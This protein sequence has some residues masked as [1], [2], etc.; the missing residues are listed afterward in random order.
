LRL[1]GR[2]VLD[3]SYNANPVS[4]AA[5]AEGLLALAGGA[6]WAVVGGMGELGQ[7]SEALHEATGRR[8]AELGIAHLVAV[9][10]NARPIAQ[11]FDAAGGMVEYCADHAQAARLLVARTAVGDRLLVKGSRATAMERVLEEL[12]ALWAPPGE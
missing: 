9:G 7:G 3:D 1:G 5:A 10:E 11:G 8:L 12:A 2:V 6:T 4:F